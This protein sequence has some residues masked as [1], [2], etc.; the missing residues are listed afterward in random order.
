M[1]ESWICTLGSGLWYIWS[2]AKGPN[3]GFIVSLSHSEEGELCLLQLLKKE[4]TA[5]G[6]F[7]SV[8]KP[9]LCENCCWR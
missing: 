2:D 9:V 1:S 6:M 5:T 7:F 3:V 8:K 4:N